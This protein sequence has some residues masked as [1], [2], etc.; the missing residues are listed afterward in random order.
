MFW[1]LSQRDLWWCFALYSSF[2]W[3]YNTTETLSAHWEQPCHWN[4][5]QFSGIFFL[6]RLF[7]FCILGFTP[8][9]SPR[10][11]FHNASSR[12]AT[13]TIT[14]QHYCH[15]LQHSPS[16]SAFSWGSAA[17]T[18]TSALSGT[19]KKVW[20]FERESQK[21]LVRVERHI[22]LFR[23]KQKYPTKCIYKRLH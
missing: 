15:G 18:K 2:P 23:Q 20:S 11:T 17:C 1:I 16:P 5:F 22:K 9:T 7:R 3:L 19:L 6:R 4:M 12:A 21:I 13:C 8:P 10:A 14:F